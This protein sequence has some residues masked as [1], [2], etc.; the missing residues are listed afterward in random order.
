MYFEDLTPYAYLDDPV[1]RSNVGWLGAG[2]DFPVGRM[3]I[4]IRNRLVSLARPAANMTRGYH[5]CEFCE[6]ESPIRVSRTDDPSTYA[7]LG[8]GEIHIDGPDGAFAAPT[9]L[10]HYID[11]HGY[12]P[13][14]PFRNAVLL[15]EE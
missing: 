7:D 8:N 3:D 5:D 13:P 2:I 11:D 1:P 10:I 15:L 9:L 6:V 14:A 12:L 4:R